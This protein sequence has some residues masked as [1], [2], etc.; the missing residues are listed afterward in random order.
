[1]T[2]VTPKLQSQPV[3]MFGLSIERI[4]ALRDYLSVLGTPQLVS[5]LPN[6]NDSPIYMLHYRI[7]NQWQ[8]FTI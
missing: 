1:M 7:D 2:V 3:C 8:S 5:V 4:H 6:V